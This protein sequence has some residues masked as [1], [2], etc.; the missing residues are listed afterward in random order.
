MQN[1]LI[2]LAVKYYPSIALPAGPNSYISYYWKPYSEAL[3]PEVPTINGKYQMFCHHTRFKPREI[4]KI[5]V[6][7]SLKITILRDPY[8]QFK[9]MYRYYGFERKFGYSFDEFVTFSNERKSQFFQKR[10]EL[11][12]F[13]RNQMLFDLGFTDEEFY[14]PTDVISYINYLDKAFDLVMIAEYFEESLVL[15]KDLLCVDLSELLHFDMKKADPKTN[16]GSKNE[17]PPV[18]MQEWLHADYLLYSHFWHKF[19]TKIEE[20]DDHKRRE[21]EILKNK[22]RLL[23]EHCIEKVVNERDFYKMKAVAHIRG[24]KLRTGNLILT[25]NGKKT[26]TCRSMSLT[27]LQM[28]K[29][30]KEAAMNCG[31]SKPNCFSEMPMY[32]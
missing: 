1:I 5:M 22:N 27:G 4:E 20:F 26:K 31:N 32:I 25:E 14:H 2:R 30:L 21:V 28:L 10:H 19:K 3:M 9:S 7:N 12:K 13:G 24:E 17:T 29:Q 18:G 16:S 23:S 15:L 8:Q 11:N 6:K